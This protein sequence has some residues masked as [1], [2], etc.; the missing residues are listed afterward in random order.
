MTFAEKYINLSRASVAFLV[1]AAMVLMVVTSVDAATKE[2]KNWRIVVKSA[3][4]VNG[5]RV[6]LGD[7]AEFYG[8]LPDETKRDLAK[9]E[10]WNAPNQG[11]KPIN[12]NRVELRAILEHYLGDMVSNCVLPATLAIQAG[13]KVMS[14][15]ELQQAVVKVLTPHARVFEGSYKFRDFKLPDYLFFADKMD[16]LKI[17][18]PQTLKPG[19][20]VFRVE[21]VSIDGQVLRNLSSSVF[22]DLWQPVPCPV[23]PLNRREVITPDMITWKNQ[24]MAH[25]GDRAWDGKGGPW[26]IKVPVG[27]GQPIM[28]S[29]IEPAPVI[30]RGDTVDLIFESPH[31]R[32]S[33]SAESL[34]DGGV[35][36]S[37]T[38]RNLQSKRKIV[39][40]VLDAQTVS[41]R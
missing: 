27:T 2:N 21:I 22:M 3:A 15:E 7:I 37:I 23:R 5:P 26:I 25:M 9:V 36:E 1:I 20:N 17:N 18:L 40:K 4:T 30:A 31:M 12:V 28:K 32:L 29:S 24:N 14:E 33:V 8:K 41:V 13:G 39:A 16:S 6:L 19:N 34:E 10:L 11:R 35:G 38:V